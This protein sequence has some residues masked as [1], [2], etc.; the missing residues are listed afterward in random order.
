MTAPERGSLAEDVLLLALHDEHG[1]THLPE[2]RLRSAL[3]S[4]T[5]MDLL[6]RGR[7]TTADGYVIIVDRRPLD[8]PVCDC[9]LQCIAA[10]KTR[11]AHSACAASLVTAMPEITTML[12]DR[13]VARGAVARERR[14]L[15]G[16]IAAGARFPERDGRIEQDLR[17][18]L[19]AVALYGKQP[20]TRTIILAT[21][22]VGYHLEGG[23]FDARERDGAIAQL[24]E[25]ARTAHQ[26]PA[27]IAATAHAAGADNVTGN[28]LTN[29][30]SEIEWDGAFE[31]LFQV[32]PSVL[33]A[34][35]DALSEL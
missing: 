22:V 17:A 5:V 30:V 27:V 7:I 4:A 15:L 23:L 18:H 10:A 6:L 12:L 3:A 28:G 1:T 35:F 24:R 9:A 19:R 26:R 11:T 20:D 33:G 31:I 21:L 32:I 2:K 14:R 16:I 8:E 13:L 34:I 29:A 25:I